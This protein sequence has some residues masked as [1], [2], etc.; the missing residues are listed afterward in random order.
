MLTLVVDELDAA[1]TSHQRRII[2][3]ELSKN[4]KSKHVSEFIQSL[5]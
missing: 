4:L 2:N 3:N 5:S 1:R